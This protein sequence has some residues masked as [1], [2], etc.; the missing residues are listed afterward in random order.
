LGIFNGDF[1][2]DLLVSLVAE[3]ILKICQHLASYG[4]V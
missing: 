4:W 1:I 3:G 2:A